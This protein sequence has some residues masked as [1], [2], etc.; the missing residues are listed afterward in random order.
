M[1]LY[2]E[3]RQDQTELTNCVKCF[4]DTVTSLVSSRP[5]SAKFMIAEPAHSTH[6]TGSGVLIAESG[7]TF[8]E[9]VIF[10]AD[11]IRSNM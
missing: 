1:L 4:W 7:S 10:G 8:S 5:V 6:Y 2:L 9:G 11:G 3:L